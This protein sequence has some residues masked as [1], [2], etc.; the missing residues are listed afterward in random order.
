MNAATAR[1]RKCVTSC[2]RDTLHD[3]Y[4]A[5]ESRCNR[6]CSGSSYC[7]T[8]VTAL[9]I[10]RSQR[11]LTHRAS[12]RHQPSLA[13]NSTESGGCSLIQCGEVH[14]WVVRVAAGDIEPP[15]D[16]GVARGA[17]ITTRSSSHARASVARRGLPAARWLPQRHVP[18]LRRPHRK[19]SAESR[20]S[21]QPAAATPSRLRMS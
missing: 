6:T 5:F 3:S 16:V 9:L 1:A 13:S 17:C 8:D 18:S 15:G 12:R 19:T 7:S 20:A 11:T 2:D 10:E 21:W 4:D 14:V